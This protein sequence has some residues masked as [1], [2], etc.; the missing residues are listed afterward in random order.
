MNRWAIFVSRSG[1]EGRFDKVYDKVHDKVFH[2][3]G[4]RQF[5]ATEVDAMRT[6]GLIFAQWR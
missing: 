6:W 4:E 3:C 2:Q 5:A 1:A